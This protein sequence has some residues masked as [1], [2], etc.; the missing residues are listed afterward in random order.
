MNWEGATVTAA[1]QQLYMMVSS[2]LGLRART[3]WKQKAGLPGAERMSNRRFD[4]AA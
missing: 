2:A 1:A 4:N 3:T